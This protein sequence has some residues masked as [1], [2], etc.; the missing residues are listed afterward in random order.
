[1]PEYRA[2]VRLA[3]IAT[4]A[5]LTA[6]SACRDTITAPR[7]QNVNHDVNV[8][9]ALT[10]SGDSGV[11]DMVFLAPLGPR[12]RPKGDLDTTLSP[13]VTICRLA[14][15]D[16]VADTLAHFTSD[17]NVRVDQRVRLTDRAYE[18]QWDLSTIASDTAA[19]YRIVVALGDTIV[20]YTDARVV[21]AG[22]RPPA[23]D[24]ARFAFLT[25]RRALSI[26]FQI[27]MPPE[28][29]TV[30]AE[31]GVH[32]S[33]V[34]GST[35]HRRGERVG[36][37]FDT[38]S[39]YTHL[40]VTVD[41][42]YLPQRGRITMNRAHVLVASADRD[43][44]VMRGDEW[45]LVEGRALLRSATPVQAAQRFL[46]RITAIVDT[47]HL[48]RRLA[49]VEQILGQQDPAALRSLDLALAGHT[50]LAGSG[51]GVE[52]P[53]V[54]PPGG[55]GGGG[56]IADNVL[57]GPAAQPRLIP[58]RSVAI[59]TRSRYEP[60]TIAYVNG[61]LTSPYGALFNAD[62]V[63]RMARA[64]TWSV[65]APFEVR[66]IYNSTA[67]GDGDDPNDRCVIEL[68]RHSEGLGI[69]ALPVYLQQ[70]LKKSS[71]TTTVPQVLGILADFA[72]AG[73]QLTSIIARLPLP[74]PADAD[75]VA[76]ITARWMASGRHV[77]FVPHSQGN[78]MVQQ[79][80]AILGR[81]GRYNPAADSTCIG[82]VALAAPTSENWPI[83]TRHLTGIVA[84][85]DAILLLGKNHF[86]Q[87]QTPLSDSADNAL[88]RWRRL[89]SVRGLAAA[90]TIRWAVR[91]HE[92]VGGYLEQEPIR[93]R[94]QTALVHSYKSCALG[95]LAVSP[96]RMVLTTG[97]SGAFSAKLLD[98]NTD[99]LDGSRVVTWSG[100]S[101]NDWQR[102]AS[103]LPDGRVRAF[104]VGGTA[105]RAA[106]ATVTTTIGVA[107]DPSPIPVTVTESLSA[108]WILMPGMITRPTDTS[109][110]SGPP[111][112]F[113]DIT[114]PWDGDNCIAKQ[115][116]TLQGGQVGQFSKQCRAT[117]RVT[118][119]PVP[120][121][122][123]YEA[124]FF[125]LRHTNPLLS[126]AATTPS[127][128]GEVS[129]PAATITMAPGPTLLDRVN[130]AAWDNAGH[131][132]STGTA[133]AHGCASWPGFL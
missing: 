58:S 5:A 72:E 105:V 70:C 119:E 60:V 99:P 61:V 121:A 132:L 86:P 116:I 104:Y 111:P 107:V 118:A 123:R 40:L 50:F 117:Y 130:V 57:P 80:V 98:L 7:A 14:G 127:L 34:S 12:R 27:F 55:G 81:K 31:P 96:E 83:G 17:T 128:L 46:D 15:Q 101:G 63:A 21:P 85:H 69:N 68:A 20:G 9:L 109:I 92:L 115:A 131:L 66:L 33:F 67:S 74:H 77:V 32:G 91:I 53:V 51:S 13:T 64:S 45:I 113:S 11:P 52:V 88:G 18:V 48:A 100:D 76:A 75:S 120:N 41:Q 126:T 30:I 106:T 29:L 19:A 16:C 65:A 37:Q 8:S 49:R 78:L 114:A 22:Y 42:E 102:A 10:A 23:G 44:S 79:G 36:Y 125:E 59:T 2:L 112:T 28:L 94:I 35:V 39:G 93:A 43:A 73:L 62:Q 6:G 87:V 124:T 122:T 110:P 103:V 1:M 97:A 71:P 95:Q 84:A 47:N 129:G 56:M 82:A 38:D 108:L 24:T 133:C 4:V 54:A 89:S 26:R 90:V 25:Q 3:V